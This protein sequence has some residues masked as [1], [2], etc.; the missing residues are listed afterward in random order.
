MI[1]TS[2]KPAERREP[3]MALLPPPRPA[4]PSL[5]AQGRRSREAGNRAGGGG[6]DRD[7]EGQGRR[8]HPQDRQRRDGVRRQSRLARKKL[9]GPAAARDPQGDADH[10]GRDSDG[11]SLAEGNGAQVTAGHAEDLEDG[12]V[13]SPPAGGRGRAIGGSPHAP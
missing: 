2:P 12:G 9:P 11:G 7:G 10:Q 3:A 13:M 4:P 8:D 5:R 6:R 1:S